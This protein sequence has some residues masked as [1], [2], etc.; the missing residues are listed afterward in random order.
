MTV[1]I[2]TTILILLVL[3]YTVA[4]GMIAIIVTDYLQFVLLSIGLGLGLL[5][6]LRAPSISWD[7]MVSTLVE[8]KGELAFNPF[9]KDSY[10]W[11]FL[12]WQLLVVFTAALCWA[13]EASRALVTED[14]ATTKRT[15]YIGSTGFFA[16]LGLPVLWGIAA[17]CY[18]NNTPQ[19]QAYFSPQNIEANEGAIKAVPLMMG[20]L[21]P[22]GLLGIVMA[23]L[24]AAH[25]S[26]HDSYLLAWATIL[27]QDVIAPLRHK[28]P[29]TD[30]QNIRITQL[31]VVVIAV[32]LL[33]WGVWYPLPKSVWEYM[34]ITGTVYLSGATT[35]MV[36]GMYWKRASSTG[37]LL[38]LSGGLFALL[39]LTPVRDAVVLKAAAVDVSDPIAVAHAI[40]RASEWFNAQTVGLGVYIVCVV[41]FIFGSLLFPDKE[42][43]DLDQKTG[44]TA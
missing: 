44:A 18:V 39:G 2:V 15:F 22:T 13:P 24:M 9:H 31:F 23:G 3:V 26:V 7:L 10:G 35:A 37:A 38:S 14:V 19:L 4:G 42:T 5:L 17:F 11:V 25:M 20:Q 36:G 40:N 32:F 28:K 43:G 30:K 34:S 12:V 29:L 33:T 27:S 16:R 41:L 21:L 6:C 8:N 1:N